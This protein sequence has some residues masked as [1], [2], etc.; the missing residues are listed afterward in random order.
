MAGGTA[1]AAAARVD[2]AQEG[3]GAAL[4]QLGVGRIADLERHPVAAAVLAG[5]MDDPVRV[6]AV[7]AHDGPRRLFRDLWPVTP[8]EHRAHLGMVIPA[9]VRPLTE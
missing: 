7:P 6:I 4:G 9:L 2:P 3:A 1:E 8:A 5:G